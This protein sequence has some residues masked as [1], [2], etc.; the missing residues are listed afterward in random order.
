MTLGSAH[1]IAI[2]GLWL[3]SV[4]GGMG[5]LF[6]YQFT[7]GAA[8]AAPERWPVH[9]SFVLDARRPTLLLVAHEH[10][11]C[12]RASLA[13]MARIMTHLRGEAV[14][15]VVLVSPE[16]DDESSDDLLEQA[17][18]IPHTTVHHDATGR[19]ADLFGARTSGQAYVY[20]PDGA[21]RFA[22]GITPSRAHEGRS[23]G[24]RAIE[25]A[26]LQAISSTAQTPV[27]GCEIE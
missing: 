19:E 10:C 6:R 16:S 25:E 27:Y 14:G 9:A 5:Y 21:L 11:T 23:E 18:L 12:T 1:V 20:A 22:G 17:R 26:I 8:A 15:H 13:E 4:A 3:T 2:V 24:H 7:P